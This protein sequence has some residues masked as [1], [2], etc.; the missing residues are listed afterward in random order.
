MKT[1]QPLSDENVA[2]SLTVR[3]QPHWNILEFCRHI[4]IRRNAI[5]PTFWVARVRL[6]TGNYRQ[7]MI[8]PVK[9]FHDDGIGYEEAL[10]IARSWFATPEI[11]SIASAPYLRRWRGRW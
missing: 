8:A 10:G 5:R 4:G 1:Q 6:K 9:L 2:L 3:E 7:H 11:Q